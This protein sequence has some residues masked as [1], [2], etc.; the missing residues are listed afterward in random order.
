MI[1]GHQRQRHGVTKNLVEGVGGLLV[2]AAAVLL[3]RAW[4]RPR[5]PGAAGNS[6]APAPESLPQTGTLPPDPARPRRRP[7]PKNQSE[8]S[9]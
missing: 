6:M 7:A 2:G 3:L 9:L 4:L 8:S 5:S 1:D